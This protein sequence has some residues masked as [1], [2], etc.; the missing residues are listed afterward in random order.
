MKLVTIG[1]GEYEG[2]YRKWDD[3]TDD[4]FRQLPAGTYL[5][6]R[7]RTMIVALD[8]DRPSAKHSYV[9]VRPI[10]KRD[11]RRGQP[12][13]WERLLRGIRVNREHGLKQARE[14]LDK[15]IEIR[16]MHRAS[17]MKKGYDGRIPI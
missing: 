11:K 17:R 12:T 16:S 7:P 10:K 1:C 4:E 15:A 3:W 6:K 2:K 13:E 9:E 8:K 14:A 5:K